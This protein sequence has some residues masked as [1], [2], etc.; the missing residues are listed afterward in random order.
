MNRNGVCYDVGRVLGHNWRPEF[1]LATIS[2]E[3]QIIRDDLH[4]NCVRICARD[5][6]RLVAAARVALELGLE[7]WLSPELWDRPP[8]ETLDYL[9]DAARRAQPLHA[10]WPGRVVFGVGTEV[11]LFMRGILPGRSLLRRVSLMRKD[12][13]RARRPDE[14]NAFLA[15][16]TTRVRR[17]FHGAL[18]YAAL[19]WEPVDWSLF[20]VIGV[21]HFRDDRVKDRYVE[22]IAPLVDSGKPVVVTEFGMR[23]YVGASSSGTLGFGVVSIPSLVLHQL[24]LVGRFIRTRLKGHQ[25]RDEDFQATEITDTLEI[26]QGA[27]VDGAFVCT[28]VDYLAPT[29]DDPRFDLDMSA[30]SIVTL[31]AHGRGTTY[32]DLTWEPKRAFHAVAS[33]NAGHPP[34]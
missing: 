7:V 30:M 34:G 29:D 16:A 22:M 23:A 1:D 8:A 12:P 11:T 5:P 27:G 21:D 28:F 33:F 4:C 26:L 31:L 2:R 13:A 19:V 10:Q 6:E 32:P 17:E 20:D 18:T 15:E 3:L 25:T 14:L 9:E 24:P